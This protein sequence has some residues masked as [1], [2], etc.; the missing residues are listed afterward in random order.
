M[1]AAVDTTHINMMPK[2]D[3]HSIYIV[4][5]VTFIIMSAIILLNLFVGVVIDSNARVTERLL[6]NNQLTPLQNEYT[7][8]MFAC[9]SAAPRAQY[10]SKG[11]RVRDTLYHYTSH[12]YFE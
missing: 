11:N 7:D 5:F 6:N 3:N 4:Y 2:V 1:W 8:I 10:I 9:Y 12:R